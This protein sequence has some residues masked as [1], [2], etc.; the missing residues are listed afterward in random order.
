MTR[1]FGFGVSCAAA[2]QN[3]MLPTAV[4]AARRSYG[5]KIYQAMNGIPKSEAAAAQLVPGQ[6]DCGVIAGGTHFPLST[7]GF[8]T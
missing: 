7:A 5:L 4:A 2:A 1:M 6:F 8:G 3:G